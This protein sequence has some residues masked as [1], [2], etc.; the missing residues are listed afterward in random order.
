[1]KKLLKHLDLRLSKNRFSWL[2]KAKL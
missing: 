2:K 1:M